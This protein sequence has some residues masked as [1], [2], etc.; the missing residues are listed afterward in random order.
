MTTLKELLLPVIAVAATGWGGSAL[1]LEEPAY[2]VV[3]ATDTY[4]VRRTYERPTIRQ[5]QQ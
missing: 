5:V 1:A 4:E 3:A 2:T